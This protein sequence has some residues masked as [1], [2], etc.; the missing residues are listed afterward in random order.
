MS[1]VMNGGGGKDPSLFL[2]IWLVII[3]HRSY[4]YSYLKRFIILMLLY[5]PKGRRTIRQ[6]LGYV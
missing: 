3:W 4:F 2:E 5:W 1:G 6:G